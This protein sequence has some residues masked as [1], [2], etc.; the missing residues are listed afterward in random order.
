MVGKIIDKGI[1]IICMIEWIF[2]FIGMKII[3]GSV[4]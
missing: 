3:F 1:E 2:L 4:N